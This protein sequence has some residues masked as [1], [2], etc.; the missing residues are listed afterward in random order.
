MTAELHVD[1]RYL[2][3]RSKGPDDNY[4]ANIWPFEESFDIDPGEAALVLVDTWNK[5]PVRS[6]LETT[7]A[8]MQQRIAPLLPLV[9]AAG[10]P[11]IYAPSPDVAPRYPQWQRRFADRARTTA[12]AAAW[13]PPEVRA[14]QG[15]YARYFR[16]PGETPLDYTGPYPEWWRW[17]GIAD[18]IAPQADDEVVATGEELHEVLS[19]RRRT[20]LFYVGF[21]TNICVLH[22]DYGVLAMGARGYLPIL[23]RDCTIGIESGDT[24]PEMLATRAAIHDVERRYYTSTADSLAR[25]CRGLTEK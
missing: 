24:L 8:I 18:V 13:P 21:A 1:V 6:H 15:P 14:R 17:D 12:T 22:R 2:A 4:E 25:A 23:L 11:L 20:I 16:R 3:M 7:G 5:H 19:E 10:I 9:R